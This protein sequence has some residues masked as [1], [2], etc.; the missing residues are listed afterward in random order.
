VVLGT[1]S[2]NVR[3]QES[4]KLLNFG[5]QSYDGARLYEK[6]QTVSTVPVW[7]GSA[8]V[9]KAGVAADLSVSIPKGMTDK[10][11]ADLVSQQPLL[12][13]ISVGQRV[14][15]IR[16]MLESKQIG[17]YPVVALENIAVAGIFGRT[18]DTVR[19]WFQ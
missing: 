16:V 4:Q 17:E 19:L 13:P 9:L 14:G 8:R 2:E 12:A 5:F 6:G 10:L 11:K 7:K 18:W 1:A 15:T 3:A